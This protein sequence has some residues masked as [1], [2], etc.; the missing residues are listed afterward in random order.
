M[1]RLTHPHCLLIGDIHACSQTLVDSLSPH[2]VMGEILEHDI[3]IL[4]DIG[5]GFSYFDPSKQE[6]VRYDDHAMLR[7][8]ETWAEAHNC[9][10]WL[11]RGNHDNPELF[12]TDFFS[13]FHRVHPLFDGSLLHA[14]DNKTYL[15]VGGAVSIDRYHRTPGLSHWENEIIDLDRILALPYPTVDGIFAHTGPTPPLLH[16]TQNLASVI[17]YKDPDLRFDLHREHVAIERIIQ[18]FHPSHW[19]NGHFHEHAEFTHPDGMKVTTLDINEA[20]LLY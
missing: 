18:Q 11:L 15:V 9:D 8:I 5:L 7:V 2:P 10:V 3:I 6:Y 14:R 1:T 17:R 13:P 4:G 19:Y 20:F 16:N 12:S